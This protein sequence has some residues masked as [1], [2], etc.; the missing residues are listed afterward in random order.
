M[1]SMIGFRW[2]KQ[3][4]LNR[5]AGDVKLAGVEPLDLS[6]SLTIEVQTHAGLGKTLLQEFCKDALPDHAR[7]EIRIII[8]AT[9]HLLDA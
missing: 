1:F 8:P 5:L 7:A 6:A 4:A 3:G 2:L 9:A